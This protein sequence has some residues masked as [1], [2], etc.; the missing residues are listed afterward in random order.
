L[1]RLTK[2]GAQ[3]RL[4]RIKPKEGRR[5]RRGQE[6]RLYEK[7]RSKFS[8]EKNRGRLREAS[9]H[10]KPVPR[11]PSRDPSR[12]RKLTSGKE[13][14]TKKRKEGRTS[15]SPYTCSKPRGVPCKVGISSL[16]RKL[17]GKSRKRIR[18]HVS[19]CAALRLRRHKQRN[20]D[21]LLWRGNRRGNSIKSD[22]LRLT[23]GE[24]CIGL[25]R[26]ARGGCRLSP[27]ERG[28]RA[29]GGGGE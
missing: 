26:C 9:A 17:G 4:N 5:K 1:A 6:R 25:T 13:D 15:Y 10:E 23:A 27:T 3:G 19:D 14:E 8:S 24:N 11:Q 16:R 20:E 22:L 28:L 12:W 21:D 7:Q 29:E 2:S 18:A